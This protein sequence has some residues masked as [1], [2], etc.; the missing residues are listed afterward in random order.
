MSIAARSLVGE[1]IEIPG[2][3]SPGQRDGSDLKSAPTCNLRLRRRFAVAVAA[4]VAVGFFAACGGGSSSGGGGGTPPPPPAKFSNATLSGK[5][6]FSMSGTEDCGSG[7]T[8]SASTFA[9]IG[10]FTADGKGRITAGLEDINSC[11]GA[12]IIDFTG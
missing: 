6:A 5:Y 10:S 2:P 1:R 11:S 12:E 4:S 8:V 9:R 7:G 3:R